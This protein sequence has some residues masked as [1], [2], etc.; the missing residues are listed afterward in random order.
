MSWRP[1]GLLMC[2]CDHFRKVTANLFAQLNVYVLTANLI[3]FF[4]A[5][6]HPFY[7]WKLSWYYSHNQKHHS[8]R[9][10]FMIQLP[11]LIAP[12]RHRT[13]T[14]WVTSKSSRRPSDTGYPRIIVSIP[15]P[16]LI[17]PN[18]VIICRS[19]AARPQ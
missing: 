8:R 19:R 15:Y 13:I 7:K 16:D 10:D 17:W 12:L 11:I 18:S 9:H 4:C 14:I 1:A 5:I 6:P 3:W 2:L